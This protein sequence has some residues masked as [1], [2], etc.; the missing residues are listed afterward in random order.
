ME[1]TIKERKGEDRVRIL[2]VQGNGRE[3]YKTE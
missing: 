3:V 2:N 1:Y